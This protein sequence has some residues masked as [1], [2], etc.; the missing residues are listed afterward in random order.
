MGLRKYSMEEEAFRLSI[1]HPSPFFQW[2]NPLPSKPENMECLP[3]LS[4][5]DEAKKS[6]KVEKME[7]NLER[8]ENLPAMALSIGL[9]CFER[10]FDE[11]EKSDKE[12]KEEE[13]EEEEKNEFIE[14]GGSSFVSENSRFWIPTPAQI[15]V[16][17][18][19][20]SCSVCHKS[21]NRYNNMQMH[22][23][24]HGSEY[25]KGSESLK[26]TQPLAM[27]KLPC[28][29]CVNGCKNNISH[30]RSKPLKDFRTLQTHYKRKHG[31]K[32]FI[33]RKCRK[34]FAV[35]GDW[36]TH[37][38][39]CG[40]LWFCS[41]GSD[42]KHKRSLNDHIRSFGNDHV[43]YISCR[44]SVNEKNLHGYRN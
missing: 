12:Y 15:L 16:G 13:E 42:F 5:L 7:N 33:C 37:E 11:E 28:Y 17:A 40:K 27:L 20:F 1:I 6:I 39:N 31:V 19:Q 24:G 38:K 41:C 22:M 10:D 9:P 35:R 43:H 26:G 8:K 23:W 30:P 36:K 4:R 34:S 32:L 29:C 21:F 18:V 3:L 2:L 25:R 44:N 14:Q